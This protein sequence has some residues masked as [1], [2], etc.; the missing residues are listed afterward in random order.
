MQIS[1]QELVQIIK[2]E[3][4]RYKK[5]KLLENKKQTILRQLNEMKTCQE[6]GSQYEESLG[7][8]YME[9]GSDT[10]IDEIEILKKLFGKKSEEERVSP[11]E[12]KRTAMKKYIENHNTYKYTA[13]DVAEKFNK[14]KDEIFEKLLDFFVKEGTLTDGGT[15]LSGIKSFV[16]DPKTNQFLNR[17]EFSAPYGPM[18]GKREL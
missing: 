10:M 17:T 11:A 12:R 15:S 2:E 3:V 5:I 9:E 6:C 1:H 14:N 16:F 4:D 18:S 8:D 7:E 13:E